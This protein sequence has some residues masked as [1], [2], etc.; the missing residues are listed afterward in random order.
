VGG[1]ER[2]PRILQVVL[3]LNPGGTERL[4][5]D[6]VTRLHADIPM[7]VC[8]LDEPGAWAPGVERLGV[9]VTAL[10][11]RPGFHPSLGAALA[12]AAARHRAT[13]IHAHHSSP[14]V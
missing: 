3:S 9:S 11:R 2:R 8:C 6:L 4:V 12:R 13:A 1:S 5:I 10:G 14:F 7:G